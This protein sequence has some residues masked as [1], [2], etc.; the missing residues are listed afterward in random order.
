MSEQ[1]FIF[2]MKS[3]FVL[4]SCHNKKKGKKLLCPITIDFYDYFINVKQNRGSEEVKKNGEQRD[5]S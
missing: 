3:W 2:E 1:L 4:Q 5:I